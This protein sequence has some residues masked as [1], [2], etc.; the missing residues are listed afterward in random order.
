[1]T[2]EPTIIIFG[3]A[4]RPDGQPSG[5]MRGRIEAALT[6][7]TG[8][9]GADFM[10]TGAQGRH[11]APEAELMA[12]LLRQRGVPSSSITLERTGRNTIR[13]VLACA[14]AL[15]GR[16]GPVYVATSA[17]HLPRCLLLL[18]LAG[19]RALPCRPPPVPASAGTVKRWLWRLREIP[20]VPV[21]S[22]MMLWLLLAGRV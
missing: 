22:A 4:V 17:Y 16:E 6:C 3:A 13:S 18:R 1:M 20:A 2:P 8:L 9:G 11:G 12:D 5:A 10:P 15:Q 14:R 7:A 19:I 21:D